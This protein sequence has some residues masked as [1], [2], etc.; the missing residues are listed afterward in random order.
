[1]ALKSTGIWPI[2]HGIFDE[3][4][5][6]AWRVVSHEPK[7]DTTSTNLRHPHLFARKDVS[8]QES[9]EI[10]KNADQPDKFLSE[11]E[12][13]ISDQETSLASNGNLFA[14]PE[15]ARPYPKYIRKISVK[16]DSG[17]PGKT[18]ILTSTPEKKKKQNSR[19]D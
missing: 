9:V 8:I 10:S 6:L 11:Q 3:I 18:R 13:S 19:S 7:I 17:K 16:Q 5:F 4:D 2:N 12:S 1:M 14:T 15:S